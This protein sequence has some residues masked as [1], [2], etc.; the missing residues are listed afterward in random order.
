MLAAAVEAVADVGYARMTVA[1]VIGRARVSRKTFYDV[2][3]DREDCFLA[4]VDGAIARAEQAI[5]DAYRDEDGWRDGIRSGLGALLALMDAEPV[6]ARLCFVETLAAGDRVLARRA[7]VLVRL[8]AAIDEGR[9]RSRSE[10]EPP[11]LTAQGVVGAV[12]SVLHARMLERGETPYSD[13]LGAL[14]SMIVLPYLGSRAAGRELAV[15]SS[16]GQ[17]QRRLPADNPADPLR[18]INMRLTYRTLRVLTVIA[19]H[20]GA[21]NREIAERS[22]ITDQGQISKLLTRLGRLELIDNVGG[23]Q[24]RGA[25]N[26]WHLTKRGAQVERA[27]RP[28]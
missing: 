16:A 14:M 3:S 22:G 15:S 19:E 9:D 6:L 11:E 24:E 4:V 7:A 18:G 25:S 2:F 26:A 5:G 28:R 21:S 20:P 17:S 10:H 23:G 27:A 12:F 1:Q 13:L 8:A